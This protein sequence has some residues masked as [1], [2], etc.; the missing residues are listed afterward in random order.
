M[1]SCWCADV[2]IILATVLSLDCSGARKRSKATCL[3]P[4]VMQAKEG[5]DV[6]QAVSSGYD[7]V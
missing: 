5:D 3:Q 6:G 4:I 7:E 1:Y 2:Q